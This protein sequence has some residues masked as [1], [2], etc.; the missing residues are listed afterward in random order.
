M[1]KIS[2]DPSTLLLSQGLQNLNSKQV[3]EAQLQSELRLTQELTALRESQPKPFLFLKS[4]NNNL[5]S[6]V[7]D[8]VII[9]KGL[10]VP[11]NN[12]ATIRDFNVNFTTTAGTIR[13]VILDSNDTILIDVLRDINSSTNGTGSTVLEEGQKLA[14]VGQSA[15]AG[16]FSVYCTGDT[17]KVI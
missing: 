7:A 17:Q 14:I 16:V 5:S 1:V 3:A 12:R 4:T 9:L 8:G 15:G 11:P 6:N 10:P 13:L 2:F